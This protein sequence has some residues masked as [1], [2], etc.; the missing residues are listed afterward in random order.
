MA[1]QSNMPVTWD[2]LH[3]V[4]HIPANV[5]VRVFCV[6]GIRMYKSTRGARM[7]ARPVQV[8]SL[9]KPDKPSGMP[10]V[11]RETWPV[12]CDTGRT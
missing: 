12:N 5:G 4:G 3:E 11:T 8:E 6:A 2:L 1:I 9:Q 10:H 7:M